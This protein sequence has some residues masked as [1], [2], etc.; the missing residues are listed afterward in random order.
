MF[1]IP[2]KRF[3]QWFLNLLSSTILYNKC[4][5]IVFI[6]FLYNNYF[7]VSLFINH[8]ALI[9][10]FFGC[11][12]TFI[13]L[14]VSRLVYIDFLDDSLFLLGFTKKYTE[15][16]LVICSRLMSIEKNFLFEL[17]NKTNDLSCDGITTCDHDF[18]FIHKNT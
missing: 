13:L 9:I 16:A 14:P 2:P 6:L 11:C 12:S 1:P 3:R 7:I 8:S 4:V 10:C 17:T 15:L 5:Y 18:F